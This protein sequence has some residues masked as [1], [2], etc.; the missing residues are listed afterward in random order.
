VEEDTL[1][2]FGFGADSFIEAI[3]G[4][5]IA[6]MVIRIQNHDHEQ[7][8]RFEKTALKV[9]GFS[10]Y[11]LCIGLAIGMVMRL[12]SGESPKSTVP[13]VII[14]LISILV[15]IVLLKMKTHIGKKLNSQPILADAS[16]TKICIYMSI[17]LLGSSMIYELTK[18]NYIDVV[19]TLGIIYFSYQEGKEAFEK[20]EGKHDCSCH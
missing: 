1:T 7:S 10:F 3:S 16:C 11:A 17:V 19:G 13:G 15:M 12:I 2:L 9:T 20:A 5:G 8:D 14:S 6:H 18:I 4:F